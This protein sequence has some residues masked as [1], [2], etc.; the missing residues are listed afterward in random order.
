[1]IKKL[2]KQ[3]IEKLKQEQINFME[4]KTMPGTYGYAKLRLTIEI[5]DFKIA[6]L[7]SLMRE[8]I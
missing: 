4:H 5:W 7:E 2:I 1:V 3:K 6:V 8:K